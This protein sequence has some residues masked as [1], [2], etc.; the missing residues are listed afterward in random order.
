MQ[1]VS[2]IITTKNSGATLGT[3]L[4]SIKSQT[5]KK[6]EIIVVDNHSTDMTVK[7][8]RK[9]TKK[10]YIQGPERSAQRNFGAQKAKGEYLFILDADMELTPRVVESCVSIAKKYKA[11]VITVAEKT[12]GDS[13]ITKIRGF[14]R[15]M[16]MGDPDI[17]VPR[18]FGRKVFWEFGGYDLSLTG[19]EDYE[20]PYRIRKKYK[21]QRCNEYILHHEEGKSL[22]LLLKRK[23]YYASHGAK[24]A[25]KHPELIKTQGNLLFRKVYIKNWKKF[26]KDPLLGLSFIFVRILETIWAIAGYIK[27]VGIFGFLKSLG[28]LVY[29]N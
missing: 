11:K 13:F 18:F 15:E 23:Y 20:L 8:A 9:F 4:A 28:R 19:P 26:L 3:L 25:D 5:Y 21:A 6:I 10:V 27:A 7:T 1:L 22:A 16:Y 29:S 17:E 14:E 12:V 2:I 24:Y